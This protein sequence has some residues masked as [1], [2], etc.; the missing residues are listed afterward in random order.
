MEGYEHYGYVDVC[1]DCYIA[2]HYGARS[3]ERPLTERETADYLAGYYDGPEPVETADGLTVTEW[4]AGDDDSPCDREPLADIIAGLTVWDATCSDHSP[5]TMECPA[6]DDG[7]AD[8]GP[9][10]LCAVCDGSAALDI[11][12]PHCGRADDDGG[13]LTD[14]T[15]SACEGCGSRL[16]GSR[17][18][19]SLWGPSDPRYWRATDDGGWSGPMT[20]REYLRAGGPP[21]AWTVL[22]AGREPEPVPA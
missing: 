15:W 9:E 10:L 5:D 4:F 11:P 21:S 7:W 2:H 19:L 14:F 3:E 20:A 18:R 1:A 8:D 22:P 12:C 6:C 16:G 13:G 17:S